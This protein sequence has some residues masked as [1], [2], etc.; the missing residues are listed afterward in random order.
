MPSTWKITNGTWDE[1]GSGIT[2]TCN[3]TRWIEDPDDVATLISRGSWVGKVSYPKVGAGAR[4]LASI[5]QDLIA[6][7]KANPVNAEISAKSIT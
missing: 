4:T 1:T 2:F 6:Q 3:I 5:R 7:A